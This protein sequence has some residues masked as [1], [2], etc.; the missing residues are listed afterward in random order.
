MTTQTAGDI[1][2]F[3][4]PNVNSIGA[5]PAIADANVEQPPQASGKLSEKVKGWHFIAVPLVV[6]A[7]WI[8][9]PKLMSS[10]RSPQHQ[11]SASTTQDPYTAYQQQQAAKETQKPV[12]TDPAQANEQVERQ[13]ELKDNFELITRTTSELQDQVRV[14]QAK[15]KELESRPQAVLAKAPVRAVRKSDSSSSSDSA[16]TLAGFKL[17]TVYA[18]QAWLQHDQRTVVVQVGDTIEGVRIVRIDPIARQVL[19]NLGV[20]R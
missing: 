14:L 13:K 2:V 5:Q 9:G 1:D 11:V 10:Q 4:K 17:N 3:A 8:V 6:V 20:I 15:V 16:K 12:D 19:T 7:I 18:D